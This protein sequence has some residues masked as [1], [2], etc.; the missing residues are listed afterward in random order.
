MAT[1]EKRGDLQWQVKVRRQ[2]YPFQSRTFN[3]KAEAQAW[4]NVI[5]S[6]MFRGIFVD[7]SLAEKTT[8]GEL[9]KRYLEEVTILKKGYVE[10][11]SRIEKLS[12]HSLALRFVATLQPSDFATYRDEGI[13][14]V[15]GGTMVKELSLLAQVFETARKDWGIYI[16]NPIRLVRK[17]KI[18]KARNRRLEVGEEQC[19]LEATHSPSLE[20]IVTFALETAM[21]R[22]ELAAMKWEHVDLNKRVLLIPETKTDEPRLVPLS[23]KVSSIL[24]TLPR[25]T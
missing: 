14:L 6:E 11:K 18:G 4:A 8:L 5:E 25:R 1:F 7:R 10:E 23:N 21:R 16:E 13:E 24:A 20:F 22:S 15:C 2:G 19:L 17:P 9:L 12:K 3:T